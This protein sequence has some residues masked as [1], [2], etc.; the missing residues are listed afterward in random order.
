MQGSVVVQA[1][2][3]LGYTEQEISALSDAGAI[4]PFAAHSA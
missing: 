4:G 3:E 1:Q 2:S